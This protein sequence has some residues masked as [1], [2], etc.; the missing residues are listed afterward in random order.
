MFSQTD[1]KTSVSQAP[2]V[3]EYS[4]PYIYTV[5]LTSQADLTYPLFCLKVIYFLLLNTRYWRLNACKTS[6]A[7][8]WILEAEHWILD[9][10]HW[11]L[12]ARNW[13]PDSGCQILDA[14][15]QI[16]D[17]VCQILDARS[18]NLD[19]GPQ[20]LD[21][22]D[23]ITCW[24]LL[25]RILMILSV[26]RILPNHFDEHLKLTAISQVPYSALYT[27]IHKQQY[28]VLL[29][30]QRARSLNLLHTLTR[31]LILT[32]TPTPTPTPTLLPLMLILCVSHIL[33]GLSINLQS[34][35]I[36]QYGTM[37]LYHYLSHCY[38]C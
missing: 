30:Y 22:G 28:I 16:L 23:W 17:T 20:M 2:Q 10:R 33:E 24:M 4:L 1:A 29:L 18:Q 6:D 34:Y 3:P 14:R 37:P 13:L 25:V 5:Q 21:A 9:T 31:I 32:L 15:Y 7:G 19:T 11:V 38:S 12:V 35:L 27:I 8:Y 26:F 36:S